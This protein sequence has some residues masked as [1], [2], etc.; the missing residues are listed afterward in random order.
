M[1]YRN[2]TTPPKIGDPLRSIVSEAKTLI[3]PSQ[4][5]RRRFCFAYLAQKHPQIESHFWR[6]AFE[7]ALGTHKP[8]AVGELLIR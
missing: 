5:V 2:I 4:L 8:K 3:V 1:Q 7:I 6:F